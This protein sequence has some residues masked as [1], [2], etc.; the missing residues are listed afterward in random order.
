MNVLLN[1]EMSF[2]DPRGRVAA[3]RILGRCAAADQSLTSVINKIKQDT[4]NISGIYVFKNEISNDPHDLYI[5][6]SVNISSR[7]IQHMNNTNSNIHL[8]NAINKY[9][10]NN[11]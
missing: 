11:F 4:K 8:H 9:G 10:K 5:G 2:K 7:F 6:S 1:K 3:P